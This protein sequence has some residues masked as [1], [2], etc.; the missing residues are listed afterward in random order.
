MKVDRSAPTV[1]SSTL[2]PTGWSDAKEIKLSWQGATDP[3]SGIASIEYA[4]DQSDFISLPVEENGNVLLDVSSLDDGQH[5]VSLRLT[6]QL[7]N[8]RTIEHTMLLDTKSP[9][10]KLL[11]PADGD[12]VTGVLDI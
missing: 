4:I 10:V 3:Y 12:W 6:D 2:E 5:T 8:S 11:S 1:S 9:E 7:G